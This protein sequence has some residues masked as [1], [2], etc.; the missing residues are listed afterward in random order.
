MSNKQDFEGITKEAKQE[1]WKIIISL[2]TKKVDIDTIFS[3]LTFNREELE[4]VK[5]TMQESKFPLLAMNPLNLISSCYACNK[6]QEGKGD[7][8]SNPPIVTPYNEMIGGNFEFKINFEDEFITLQ[9]NGG[10]AHENYIKL[11]KLDSR[12][13]DPFIFSNVDDRA[14]SLFE[15]LSNYGSPSKQS[16]FSYIDQREKRENLSFALR[17][18]ISKYPQFDKYK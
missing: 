11:L 5:R 9:N 14:K 6:A 1:I 15:S 17:S 2:L 12:Y 18:A 8:V 13:A 3:V 16:I 4:D 7:R 10:K